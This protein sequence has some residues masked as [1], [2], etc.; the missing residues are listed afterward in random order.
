MLSL[1]SSLHS[2]HLSLPFTLPEE[3]TATHQVVAI[4]TG[5]TE[6]QF[7]DLVERGD[8]DLSQPIYLLVTQ[9][10]NSLAAAMEILTW[11]NLHQGLAHILTEE[12]K[13]EESSSQTTNEEPTRLPDFQITPDPLPLT[14]Y[15]LLVTPD[16][17]PLT[18]IPSIIP[19][20][21]GIIGSP[22]DWLIASPYSP[23]ILHDRLGIDIVNIPITEVTSLGKVESG[24]KGAERIYERL[25]EIIAHYHLNAI[26]LRCFDLLTTVGNTGCIALS[27]LNDE[28]IPAS[29][30]GDVPTLV[31]MLLCQR[32][33][34][35]P[36]FQANPARIDPQSGKI[37]MAHCTLPLTMTTS[38]TLT[39]HFESGIGVAIHG[40]LPEGP[41]TLVKVSGD[42]T[43]LFAENV[44]LTANQYAPDLCRTQVWLQTT[45]EAAQ[46]LLF[47]PI[48]NHHVLIPGHWKNT[49][50]ALLSEE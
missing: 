23:D 50:H 2:E 22:S 24:L 48:A 29:C 16:P 35:C 49:F 30:E 8:I 21:I 43:R 10:S 6:H 12:V 45:P 42:L 31:T 20:T 34:G 27:R 19:M 17:L 3:W 28:G 44:T 39:T 5:G 13:S 36:G 32:L 1:S 40:E 47:H 15:P 7:L 25:K 41:Y 18:H 38:H 46:R 11:I 26:T 33:T 9:R 4:L 14:H 37:L